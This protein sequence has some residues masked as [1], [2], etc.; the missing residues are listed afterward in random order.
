MKVLLK[1]RQYKKLIREVKGVSESSI[2]YINLIYNELEKLMYKLI[3]RGKKFEGEVRFDLHEIVPL[4][5]ENIDSFIDFPIEDIVISLTLM[6]NKKPTD[7]IGKTFSTN[8]AAYPITEVDEDEDD[9]EITLLIEPSS[10]LPLSVLEN[11]DKVL[12][13]KFDFGVT[14]FK[15]FDETHI[16]EMLYDLRDTITH[17]LN[18]MYEFFKR[19]ENIGVQKMNLALSFAG[20]KNV[21]TPKKI[22]N[23]YEKFLF[24]L[25]YSEPWE[26]NA[27]VQE[28]LSKVLRMS[29]DEFKETTQWKWATLM[30]NFNAEE[31][32]QTLVKIT[33]E[34]TPEAVDFHIKGL[35]KQYKKQYIK[36]SFAYLEDE[37]DF[38]T[39]KVLKTNDLKGLFKLFQ[40][41]I[42]NAGRTLKKKYMRLY[43]V[44]RD[45]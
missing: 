31:F 11:V 35:H 45:E 26:I 34:R 41:R 27:N 33:E 43:T 3:A 25:Y 44:D 42:N 5:N 28:A 21:N 13:A 23:E 30:E 24:M 6:Y 40:N 37:F 32:Y 1:E 18:H 7:S 19:S 16:D 9:G 29:F 14:L 15:N 38:M 17:E 22:Y 12:R 36:L 20:S 39:D 4:A 8:G 2:M 10:E